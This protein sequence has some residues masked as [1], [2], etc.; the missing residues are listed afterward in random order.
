MN[1]VT[2]YNNYANTGGAQDISMLIASHFAATGKAV[3]LTATSTEH[4]A[5]KYASKAVFRL[6]TLRNVLDI[7]KERPDTVFL[8]HDRKSTAKLMAYR[9]FG[10]KKIR[11][12][13]IAHSVFN[14][15]RLI[16]FLPK[17]I[18]SISTAV[19]E[20]LAEYFK[21]P[22][23]HITYIPNG[24]SDSG[25]RPARESTD[26]NILLA[27]RICGVKRQVEIAKFMKG[28]LPDNVKL[29]FAGKG[30]DEEKLASIVVADESMHYLG[31]ISIDEEI[32]KYDYM[33]LFSQKEGLPLS[34]IEACMY[35]RPM[36]TNNHPAM[37]DVNVPGKCG[38]VFKDLESLA[39]GLHDLPLPSSEEYKRLSSNARRRYEE[40]FQIDRMLSD[41]EK[42]VKKVVSDC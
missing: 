33:L 9:C 5:V 28:R 13:H 24:L 21:I 7:V 6:L 18:V 20:N 29:Y 15:L 17:N 39:D 25:Q 8:S 37:L 10:G 22:R 26:I 11:I 35:G 40:N 31:Q 12:V 16:T 42:L 36:I 3:V 14:D 27:G 4:I 2:V 1:I 30:E 32:E 41:Y 23:A 38:F 34:L 19:T